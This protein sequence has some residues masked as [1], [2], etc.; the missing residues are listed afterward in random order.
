MK[1]EAP[2]ALIVV[3]MQKAFVVGPNAVPDADRVLAAVRTQ[4]DNARQAGAVIVHLQNDGAPGAPDQPDTLGWELALPVGPNEAV[5]RKTGDDGFEGT[6]LE[7]LLREEDVHQLSVCGLTSEMCVAATARSALGRGFGVIL[8]R[9]AH[10][11]YDVPEDGPHAPA[12]PAHLAARVAEWSLG[13]DPAIIDRSA[14]LSF[15]RPVSTLP[16]P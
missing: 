14:D 1:A 16:R 8:A 6:T 9:D 2:D 12:V 4:L 13:T 15:T 5:L 7:S 10:A 11:T 3:D